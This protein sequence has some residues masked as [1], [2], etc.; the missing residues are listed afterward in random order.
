MRS[1]CQRSGIMS[2]RTCHRR[3]I[4]RSIPQTQKPVGPEDLKA[5][6]PMELIRQEVT[7][8]RYIDIPEE[9]QEVLHLWR[10][11][12]LYRAHRLEKFLKTPA[13]IY[14][15]WEGVS[16]AGSHKTKHVDPPGIL[17]HE[18]GD[19]ADRDRDRCRPVGICAG[20]CNDALRSRMHDLYGQVEL[21]PETLPQ[22]DDACLG[23]GMYPEPQHQDQFRKGSAGKGPGY[24]GCA[25]DCNLRGSRGCSHPRQ[26]QLRARFRAEPCLP[27]PDNHRSG[28]PGAAC[29]GRRLPGCCHRL[30]RW[31]DP[32]L[33]GSRS[34][35]RGTR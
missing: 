11:S 33:P 30:C 16:P 29:H 26:H 2:R 15:K 19:G 27:P 12:P 10:P 18:S 34:R 21:Y 23:C 7:T 20:I 13:K 17:Q 5:I 1:R 8:D 3:W 35:L 6:F 31:R 14:Y 22:V 28:M 25:G 9:V 4:H 32:T 24:P